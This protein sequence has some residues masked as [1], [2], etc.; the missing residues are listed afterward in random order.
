VSFNRRGQGKQVVVPR[1]EVTFLAFGARTNSVVAMSPY[2]KGLVEV[3]LEGKW[4]HGKRDSLTLLIAPDVAE[5][6]GTDLIDGAAAA[7]EDEARV[8]GAD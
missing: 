2:I 6:W 8:R 3:K 1:D 4:N 5:Q 7:R